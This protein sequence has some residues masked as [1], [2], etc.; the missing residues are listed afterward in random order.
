MRKFELIKEYPGFY[1]RLG[2]LAIDK[3]EPLAGHFFIKGEPYSFEI[4][5]FESFPEFWKEVNDKPI[6]VTEDG[7][8]LFSSKDKVFPVF[9]SGLWVTDFNDGH[10]ISLNII[11]EPNK[12]WKYFSTKEIA[13]KYIYDNKPTFSRKQLLDI[14]EKKAQNN[15]RVV[16]DICELIK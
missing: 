10:G 15:G 1:G 6:F 5:Y 7:V 16:D 9:G 4:A 2:I 13:E 14:I 3:G 12:K 8:E 11:G